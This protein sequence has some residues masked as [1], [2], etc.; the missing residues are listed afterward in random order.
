[1]RLTYLNNLTEFDQFSPLHFSIMQS[2]DLALKENH[3]VIVA[4][5]S[6]AAGSGGG[7]ESRSAPH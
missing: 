6:R 7:V 2:H 3:E 1:M 4:F 5:H